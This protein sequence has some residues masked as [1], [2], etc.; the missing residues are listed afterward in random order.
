MRQAEQRAAGRQFRETARRAPRPTAWQKGVCGLLLTMCVSVTLGSCGLVHFSTRLYRGDVLPLDQVALLEVDGD[1]SVYYEWQ[2]YKCY[3]REGDFSGRFLLEF[4]PGHHK[5]GVG[6]SYSKPPL[7]PYT[8]TISSKG[9]VS[10]GFDAKPGHLYNLRY[11][12]DEQS[13]TWQPF[14]TE[15]IKLRPIPV[16][17]TNR[18]AGGAALPRRL[19]FP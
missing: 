8:R 19:C 14:I 4:P 16:V 9:V 11:T 17:E 13:M 1:L 5:I 15:G 7:Y 2:G 12:S 3:F 18:K 10:L 6:L